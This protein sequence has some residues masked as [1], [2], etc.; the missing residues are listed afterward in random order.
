MAATDP[1][2]DNAPLA[3]QARWLEAYRLGLRVA[4]QGT[5][6]AVGDGI[7]WVRGLP[8]AAMDDLLA[9]SEGST[10]LVF[11]LGRDLLGAILLK[12][13]PALSAGTVAQVCGLR[14]SIAVGDG[15]LGRIIDPLGAP[16]DGL[17]P[18]QTT[19]RG[20]IDAPS[21]PIVARDFVNEAL[22]TGS[23]IVDSMIPIGKGQRQL[24]I[25]DNGLGKTAFALD[26]VINQKGKGVYCVYVIVGQKRSSVVSVIETLR[27]AGALAHTTVL[28]A[29]ASALP[30]LKYLAPFAGCTVA[31]A[32]MRQGRDTLVVYDDLSTHARTYRELSL[33]L[34]RPPGRE[35]Y[36]GDIFYLHSRLL[37]RSTH[38]NAAQGGGSMTALPIVETE[39]GEI[40]TYIPTN[41][42]SITDG[43]IYF[44]QRLFAAGFLPAIDVT[45][46][47]SRIGGNAQDPAVKREAGRLKLDYLQFLELE[48]FTRFGARLEASMETKIRRGRMLRDILKQDRLTPWTIEAQLLWM[49]A[50]N[51]GLLDGVAPAAI[52]ALLAA[53][54]ARAAAAGLTLDMARERWIQAA[55][56][57][58]REAGG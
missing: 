7:I 37:E 48:V 46:S 32:W 30:G 20:A 22:Y 33:L 43:Q 5:V 42:I 10:A 28:V 29:E 26:T 56:A 47:V 4:E 38:L 15:L 14:L 17:A 11:H 50:F 2:P 16:L 21:P 52:P 41:L 36:P 25:G 44:E 3:R 51:D 6:V 12:E 55:T 1:L 24:L 19:A 57:W 45:K 27:S 40:A 18:P 9:L 39:L 34:R 23:K 13:S 31:E 35:A 8:S 49:V 58:I 53:L 54:P